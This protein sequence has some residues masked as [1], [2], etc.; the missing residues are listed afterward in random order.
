MSVD[1]S[2][3]QESDVLTTQNCQ[4][5]VDQEIS[6]AAT[7]EEDTKRRQEN[8]K[9]DLADIAIKNCQFELLPKTP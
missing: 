2:H 7:L 1:D 3:A 9:N 6:S 5:D 8:G 4:Q